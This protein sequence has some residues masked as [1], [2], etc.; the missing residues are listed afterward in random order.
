MEH[1]KEIVVGLGTTT[2]KSTI[3]NFKQ[4][5]TTKLANMLRIFSNGKSLNR[6][7]AERHHDHCL[8]TTVSVLQNSYKIHFIRVSETVPCLGG[9]ATVIV[10]R[11]WIDPTP[12]NIE[13]VEALLINWG[14]QL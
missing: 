2:T 4:A 6:F 9:T 13:R 12:E 7:E 1:Q 5:K 11:Y 8:N 10:K 14:V 3:A